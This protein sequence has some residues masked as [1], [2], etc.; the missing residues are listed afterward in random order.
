MAPLEPTQSMSPSLN[1]GWS[2]TTCVAGCL[3]MADPPA[4]CVVAVSTWAAALCIFCMLPS[5][6]LRSRARPAENLLAASGNC[7]TIICI[8]PRNE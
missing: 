6:L 2:I 4:A 1:V 8:C 3:G 7:S 5:W